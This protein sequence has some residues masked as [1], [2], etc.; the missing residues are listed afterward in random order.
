LTGTQEKYPHA[1]IVVYVDGALWVHHQDIFIEA[2]F[3][4]VSTVNEGVLRYKLMRPKTQRTVGVEGL[5][6]DPVR[7]SN[8][9]DQSVLADFVARYEKRYKEEEGKG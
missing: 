8:A 3:F 2:T 4:P 7:L 1:E 5:A 6:T 9:F